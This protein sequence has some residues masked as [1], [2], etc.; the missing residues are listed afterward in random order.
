M[1]TKKFFQKLWQSNIIHFIVIP[2]ITA[3]ILFSIVMLF[4]LRSVGSVYSF[5]IGS[6]KISALTILIIAALIYLF[7]AIFNSLY[8][9]TI[10]IATIVLLIGIVNEIKKAFLDVAVTVWD[11][12]QI[13][14][15]FLIAPDALGT[16]KF[17][18]AITLTIILL[19]LL[20]WVGIKF[21]FHFKIKFKSIRI[22]V[23]ILSIFFLYAVL[24]H[25]EEPFNK[26][27]SAFD[28]KANKFDIT[29]AANKQGI[30]LNL[31]LNFSLLN[32]EKPEGYSKE[33][34]QKIVDEVSSGKTDISET[35]P[36]IIV[37]M[38]EAFY[39]VHKLNV[40]KDDVDYLPTVRKNQLG[41][42]FVSEFGGR[43]SNI[44]FEFLM[45]MSMAAYEKGISPYNQ[46]IRR[47]V[48]TLPSYL[49]SLGYETSGFHTHFGTFYNRKANYKYLG[50]DNILFR[51]D[52]ENLE[53][54]GKYVSDKYMTD[55]VIDQLDSSQDKP[56]F[57]FA[58]TMQ[59]HLPYTKDREGDIETKVKLSEENHR[60]LKNYTLGINESDE[61]FLRLFEYI[62]QRE[63][64][65][66]VYLFGDHLPNI[67]NHFTVYR[68]TKYISTGY[69]VDWND[70]E[71]QKMFATPLA[72]FS[73]FPINRDRD[74]YKI[75][76]NYLALQILNELN[77]ND[78]SYPLYNFIEKLREEYPVYNSIYSF[79][80]NGRFQK[81]KVTNEWSK[82]YEMLQ[83]DI[84]LGKRYA[85]QDK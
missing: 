84:L 34:I 27:F 31:F 50:F 29:K 79:D 45:S 2:I 16:L 82:K 57:I 38:S 81:G 12:Y 71:I 51:E 22:I 77:L 42:L 9:S 60:L 30:I 18:L 46:Y 3:V 75:S 20:I 25:R 52:M 6:T 32:A 43:T 11:I 15:G 7:Y 62:Q 36:D 47:E 8:F 19:G 21:K 78:H 83:Y 44:E 67:S 23:T 26:Y 76:P 68:E 40:F 5:F 28:D 54:S 17:T 48:P 69:S 10:L 56:Q 72:S 53:F 13:K 61:Q 59:N 70:E 65:T 33:T 24:N 80:K 74:F 49:K 1:N 66:V 63:R 37:F 4:Q 35:K 39:D 64:P 85:L 41:E 14:Q 58:L 73:N 55:L